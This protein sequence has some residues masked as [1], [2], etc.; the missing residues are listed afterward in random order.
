MTLHDYVT[1]ETTYSTAHALHEVLT[2]LV[3]GYFVRYD[4]MASP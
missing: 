4:C 3:T 1:A 2:W